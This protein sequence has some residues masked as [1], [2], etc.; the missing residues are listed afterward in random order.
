M[1][2]KWSRVQDF[3]EYTL[4]YETLRQRSLQKIFKRIRDLLFVSLIF[5]KLIN[6]NVRRQVVLYCRKAYMRQYF[7]FSILNLMFLN[8]LVFSWFSLFNEFCNLNKIDISILCSVF[9]VRLMELIGFMC[10]LN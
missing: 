6:E 9:Y 3:I 10:V 8:F 5:Y 7:C 4:C 2:T 1:F